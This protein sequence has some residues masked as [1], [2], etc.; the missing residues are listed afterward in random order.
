MY[1]PLFPVQGVSQD[2]D[3]PWTE[4][5]LGQ[6]PSWTENP[7]GQ[8]TSWSREPTG[9]RS[10]LNRDAPVQRTSLDSLWSSSSLTFVIYSLI[11][12]ACSL[13]FFIPFPLPLGVNRPKEIN[14]AVERFCGNVCYNGYFCCNEVAIVNSQS[15]APTL[16]RRRSRSQNRTIAFAAKGMSNSGNYP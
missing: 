7:P 13:I 8:R 10:P 2:R 12:S 15:V 6:R 5:T 11:F 3:P 16:L 14:C 4:T 9:Q 1:C